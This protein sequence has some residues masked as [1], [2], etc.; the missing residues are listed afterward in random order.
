MAAMPLHAESIRGEVK[1]ALTGEP[2]TGATVAVLGSD[3]TVLS[4]VNE[5]GTATPAAAVADIA[6]PARPGGRWRDRARPG[7]GAL[8]A[9]LLP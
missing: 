4:V 3:L 9:Q 7:H 8:V 6:S 2:L 5:G 1:D